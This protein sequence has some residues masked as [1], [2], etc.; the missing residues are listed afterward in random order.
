MDGGAPAGADPAV[1]DFSG[2]DEHATIIIGRAS[3]ATCLMT[4]IVSLLLFC[5]VVK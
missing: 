2:S 1:E 5:R 4:F 3:S